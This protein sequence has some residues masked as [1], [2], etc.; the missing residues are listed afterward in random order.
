MMMQD[1]KEI[2]I[3]DI[4][5]DPWPFDGAS[6]RALA[7]ALAHAETAGRLMKMTIQKVCSLD[8]AFV[9]CLS[10]HETCLHESRRAWFHQSGTTLACGQYWPDKESTAGTA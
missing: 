4:V 2:S 5:D 10:L 7:E 1:M 3:H 8:C 6:A 9:Q